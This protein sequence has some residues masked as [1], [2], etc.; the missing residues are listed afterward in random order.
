MTFDYIVTGTNTSG[1]TLLQSGYYGP[2]SQPIHSCISSSSLV[3]GT[4]NASQN[5]VSSYIH[6]LN[7]FN[8]GLTEDLY[9]D[10]GTSPMMP[11]QAFDFSITANSSRN[12]LG[13]YQ[14]G[15]SVTSTRAG[16]PFFTT[17]AQAPNNTIATCH[18]TCMEE[19]QLAPF[20]WG[21]DANLEPGFINLQNIQINLNLNLN[22]QMSIQK[23]QGVAGG[24]I[25]VN[26]V[27]TIITGAF[28]I[29]ESLTPPL[30]IP[31]PISTTYDYS[32][33]NMV[34]TPGPNV[35]LGQ[36]NFPIVSLNVSLTSVPKYIMIFAGRTNKS[37]FNTDAIF[38]VANASG[39]TPPIQGTF[40]GQPMFLNT[41]TPYN[42]YLMARKSGLKQSWE[43][44][45]YYYGSTILINLQ[46]SD[47]PLNM[48]SATGVTK[49]INMQFTCNFDNNFID[50]PYP[51]G[52]IPT[53]LYVITFSGGAFNIVNGVSEIQESL[54][55]TEDVAHAKQDN[56]V[57][58][59]VQAN[60]KVGGSF[61]SNAVG[62]LAGIANSFV[63]AQLKPAVKVAKS[64]YCNPEVRKGL[65]GEGLYHPNDNPYSGGAYS[66]GAHSG[67][68]YDMGEMHQ[69]KG[70]RKM[71]KAQLAKSLRNRM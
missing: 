60:A 45:S 58:S 16:F 51:A 62:T 14:D 44:W 9:S 30:T 20:C 37:S 3:V 56:R 13:T 57:Q 64:I 41:E 69:M 19:L 4:T 23:N 22:N 29:L 43:Q 59:F 61:I 32:V 54:L 38:P 6:N 1:S 15:T 65:C 21:K 47:I 24:L 26:N 48:L 10:L 5:N 50:N 40:D 53:T 46:N 25:N 18:L 27:Q 11:D 17:D 66:G 34:T 39:V 55:S 49:N 12:P 35:M 28:V 42:L 36:R 8:Q 71:T 63:P 33:I 31:M 70:G 52:G 68:C 2:K 67:G 7:L